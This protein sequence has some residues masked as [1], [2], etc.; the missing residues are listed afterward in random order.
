VIGTTGLSA[1][2]ERRDPQCHQTRRRGAVRQHELGRQLLAALVKRV[3][4]SLDEDFDIEIL[5]MH[6][7]AKI[8][9]P[10]GT[11][12]LLGE[13][14]AEGRKIELQSRSVRARDGYTGARNPAT[15]A[16]R[17]CAGAPW[18]GDHTVILRGLTS[19]LTFA[20]GRRSHDFRA[21]RTESGLCGRKAKSLLL[22]NGRR[23]RPQQLIS[24][25]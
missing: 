14:A 15:S 10:S 9:A 24:K 5:E 16:L 11:A 20:Q 3:A 4:Q 1:S 21:R 12:Y 23:A 8:D 18:T 6:P 2:D 19:G 25:A 13:A 7:Q 17:R 22:L